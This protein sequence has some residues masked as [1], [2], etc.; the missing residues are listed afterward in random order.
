MMRFLRTANCSRD[1]AIDFKYDGS[2]Y[3][4]HAL[5]DCGRRLTYSSLNGVII[6]YL[7][8]RFYHCLMGETLETFIDVHV[9]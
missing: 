7:I 2:T 3:T 1:Y 8:S 5:K 4:P 6:L 9:I